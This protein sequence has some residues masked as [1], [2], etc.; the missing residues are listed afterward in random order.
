MMG[1]DFRFENSSVLNYLWM[2]PFIAVLILLAKKWMEKKLT[3]VIGEKALPNL[4]S[5]VEHKKRKMNK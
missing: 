5:S 4:I 3:A 1:L 2:I